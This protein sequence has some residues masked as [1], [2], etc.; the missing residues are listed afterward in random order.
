LGGATA[1]GGTPS[2]GV[3][4]TGGTT[5]NGVA[6]S[7]GSSGTNTQG[8]CSCNT[9]HAASSIHVALVGLVL[10]LIVSRPR[11]KKN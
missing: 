6:P 7:G 5:A 10:F 4:G 2:G 9:A 3:A 8:G 11:R 1:L